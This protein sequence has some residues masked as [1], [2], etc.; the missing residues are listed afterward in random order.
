MRAIC[1]ACFRQAQKQQPRAHRT[2]DVRAACRFESEL[3]LT[4]AGNAGDFGPLMR[5]GRACCF[6][7]ALGERHAE[8]IAA[9]PKSM[10]S[11]A[12]ICITL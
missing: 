12:D 3:I 8:Q 11:P 6:S 9:L 2:V 5:V 1:S 10:A 4:V 7:S